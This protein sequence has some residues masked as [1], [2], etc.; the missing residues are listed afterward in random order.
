LT[1]VIY[2]KFGENQKK[3]QNNH[4]GF[5]LTS[6]Q[7]KWVEIQRLLYQES[8]LLLLL[9]HKQKSVEFHFHCER[10]GKWDLFDFIINAMIFANLITMALYYEGSSS[11]LN[12]IIEVLNYVVMESSFLKPPLKS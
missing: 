1:G 2:T 9:L 10:A 8:Q 6:A 11:K 7:Q 12:N 4:R 3:A 5:G